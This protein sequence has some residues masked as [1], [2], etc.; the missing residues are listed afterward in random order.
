M[1]EKLGSANVSSLTDVT[2]TVHY[3]YRV[4]ITNRHIPASKDGYSFLGRQFTVNNLYYNPVKT[5]VNHPQ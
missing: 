4:H 1:T 2:K 3:N 5:C